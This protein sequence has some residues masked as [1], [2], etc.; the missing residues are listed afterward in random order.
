M[1]HPPL[2]RAWQP[3]L[4]KLTSYRWPS[5]PIPICA[6][7][8][9]E[10][11]EAQENLLWMKVHSSIIHTSQKVKTTSN[12][13]STDEPMRYFYTFEYY[14]ARKRNEILTKLQQRLTLKIL[15]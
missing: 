11:I 12:C 14:L 9:D 5:N 15:H 2:G 10:N 4:R 13:P 1:E 8:R 3:F 6:L 7:I